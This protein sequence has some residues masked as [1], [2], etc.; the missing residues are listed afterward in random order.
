[1]KK[2]LLL[3]CLAIAVLA[4]PVS[5]QEAVNVAGTWKLT[6]ETPE[7]KGTPTLVLQQAGETLQGTYAGRRGKMPVTGAIKGT[8]IT[9][10]V[11]ISARG[12]DRELVF[13]GTVEA[14]DNMKGTVDLAGTGT[15]N[16]SGSRKK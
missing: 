14:S 11:K 8:T 9:Y 10:S 2:L 12:Q 3:S 7:G 1:M 4:P 15:G 6:L 5:A 13:S 16:W